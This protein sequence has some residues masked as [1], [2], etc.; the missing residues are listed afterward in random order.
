MV[1]MNVVDSTSE[2]I[3]GKLFHLWEHVLILFF[4]KLSGRVYKV[5]FA[6]A[7]VRILRR[8]SPVLPIIVIA[9][10]LVI[11]YITNFK[12]RLLVSLYFLPIYLPT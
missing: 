6:Y 7:G 1:N 5:A 12:D 2:I 9:Q 11:S 4:W 3:V 8:V 10:A